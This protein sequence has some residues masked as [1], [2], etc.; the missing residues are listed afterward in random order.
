MKYDFVETGCSIWNTY[1]DKFGLQAKGILVEPLPNLFDVAPSPGTVFKENCA[2][3]SYD[4]TVSMYTYD[5]FSKDSPVEYLGTKADRIPE[6]PKGWGASSID[7]NTNPERT[8]NAKTEVPCMTLDSLFKKYDVTELD[9]FKVDAEGHDHIVL[10]Q[11]LS[12]MRSGLTINKEIIFEYNYA[13]CDKKSLYKIS[14]QIQ[15]EFLF[16]RHSD[17]ADIV[18]T[19]REI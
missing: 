12:L 15:E 9:H 13:I 5:L 3:T 6:M 14:H 4:E 2:I 10:D 1:A 7:I 16:M 17:G 8:V 11:L 19:K 18:L